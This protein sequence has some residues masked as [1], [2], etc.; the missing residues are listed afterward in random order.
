MSISRSKHLILNLCKSMR[1]VC[2][3]PLNTFYV[4]NMYINIYNRNVDI[5]LFPRA[6][7]C[8]TCAHVVGS[9][10]GGGGRSSGGSDDDGVTTAAA[11]TTKAMTTIATG[12][13]AFLCSTHFFFFLSFPL[14]LLCPQIISVCPLLAVCIAFDSIFGRVGLFFWWKQSLKRKNYSISIIEN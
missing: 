8:S 14:N 1:T 6:T 7:V 4:Y 5:V 3:S 9:G 13:T 12:Y 2:L 10:G 11:A